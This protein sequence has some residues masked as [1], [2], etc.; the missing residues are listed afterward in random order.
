MSTLGIAFLLFLMFG[1]AAAQWW[2]IFV[3]LIIPA[4]YFIHQVLTPLGGDI[5]RAAAT[6]HD[7]DPESKVG[8]VASPK[9]DNQA[10]SIAVDENGYEC[11]AT[12]RDFREKV[13]RA[14]ERARS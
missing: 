8:I 3:F 9:V 1:A 12:P 14:N 7:P 4:V 10:L 2:L 11:F 13:K 6:D 5:L